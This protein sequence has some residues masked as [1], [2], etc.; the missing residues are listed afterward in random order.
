[1]RATTVNP[2]TGY[3]VLHTNP[4]V[5]YEPFSKSV[6]AFLPVSP[7][8]SVVTFKPIESPHSITASPMTKSLM[9]KGRSTFEITWSVAVTTAGKFSSP[10][11]ESIEYIE[12]LWE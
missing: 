5:P 2:I 12:T 8:P 1:M 10:R 9:K 4:F 11:I 7:E 3:D 6:S